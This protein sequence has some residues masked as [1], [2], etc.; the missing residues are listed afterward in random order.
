MDVEALFAR[1]EQLIKQPDLAGALALYDQALAFD[2]KNSDA[3]FG[4]A[5]A[6]TA[7]QRHEDAVVVLSQLL[8]L[9]PTS[10]P[11]L[12]MRG[13]SRIGLHQ[14]ERAFEDFDLAA[15]LDPKAEYAQ[16]M[17]LY[18]AMRMCRWDDFDAAMNDLSDR[19]AAGD[20]VVK[21]FHFLAMSS[22]PQLHRRCAEIY[23]RENAAHSAANA[24]SPPMTGKIKLGY[25]SADFNAH[26]TSHLIAGLFRAHD[27]SK[28]EVIAYSLTHAPADPVQRQMM[29]S[30][31]RWIDI[32]ALPDEIIT[33]RV[34]D[35][36][37][38]IALDLNVYT[39]RQPAFFARRVAPIQVNYLGFPGTAGVDCYD[40]VIGDPV[41]TPREH[42]AHF[43]ERIVT[44]PHSYQPTDF[45]ALSRLPLQ[46]R[47]S[48][49]LP[50][51]R[52]VFCCFNDSFKI[53]PDVF[54]IWMNL[55]RRV[56]G[57]VLWLLE[58]SASAI[59]NLRAEANKRGVAE[60][61]IVFAPRVPLQDHIARHMAADL[62]LDTFYYNAHTT[63]S[64]ALWA[65]LPVLTKQG[66]TFP[67]RVAASLVTAAGIPELITQSPEAYEGLAEE[68]A[69]RPEKLAHIKKQLVG[70]RMTCPLFD[71]VGYARD[72]ERAYHE[73]WR[74][75][76]AGLPL[77]HMT[78]S[79]MPRAP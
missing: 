6:L 5:R 47:R 56:E 23:G 3:H 46:N 15:A 71:T 38:H 37:V 51:D 74:R 28:F 76:Q 79:E 4:K 53:T 58:P 7:F 12:L 72:I 68:L 24:P 34:R 13:Q 63:T 48:L 8:A 70:G 77:D 75:H 45:R 2:P 60:S 52:F 55:L 27:R 64:D 9:Q 50:D 42:A 16:G 59:R 14:Y 66:E 54:A 21:P 33:S 32:S 78:I 41:V 20:A 69:T 44:L 40:Y 1:A 17:A 30:V 18:L 36:G 22:S 25:F 11:A 73:M 19:I 61:R 29:A 62:F 39:H 67:S 35:D 65:G 43:S 10:V 31:D 26:A 49:N 57:S